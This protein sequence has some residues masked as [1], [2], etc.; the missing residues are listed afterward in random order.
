MSN[1][2]FALF[3]LMLLAL[4]PAISRATTVTLAGF[5]YSGDS[6]SIA[7]RFPYSKQLELTQAAAGNPL[8]K[9]IALALA[10][11][12][13]AN[14]TLKHGAL[15]ELKGQDQAIVVALVITGET[16]SAERFGS[17]AKLL[18]QVR[19]QAMFFDFK[20]A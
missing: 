12:Q 17:V 3:I 1:R 9:Q 2:F 20:T 6:K 13:P 8:N 16:V 5:A 4:I 15:S 7:T 11:S 18:T 19:A 14:F 10:K